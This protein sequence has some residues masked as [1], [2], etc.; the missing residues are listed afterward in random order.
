M[1]FKI[2]TAQVSSIE[3]FTCFP[4]MSCHKDFNVKYAAQICK[5]LICS[6]P[7]HGNFSHC[8][9]HPFREASELS[10]QAIEGG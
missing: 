7:P 9:S 6:S 3:I 2:K 8:P 5:T 10:M 1:L 4:T